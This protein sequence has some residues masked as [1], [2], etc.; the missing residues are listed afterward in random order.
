LADWLVV[1][2]D[3]PGRA[4]WSAPRRSTRPTVIGRDQPVRSRPNGRSRPPSPLAGRPGRRPAAPRGPAVI[5]RVTRWP[6]GAP[7][8]WPVRAPPR[9]HRPRAG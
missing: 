4:T 9:R 7:G 2:A 3:S 8:P 6:L 1:R 5:G